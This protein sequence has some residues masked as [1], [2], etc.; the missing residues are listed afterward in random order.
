MSCD[1]KLHSCRKGLFEW[2]SMQLESLCS[3]HTVATG[4]NASQ[5]TFAS[6]SAFDHGGNLNVQDFSHRVQYMIILTVC[7]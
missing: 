6:A 1:E 2:S 4:V 5:G 7:H 3:Q